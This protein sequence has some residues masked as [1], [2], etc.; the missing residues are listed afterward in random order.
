V[1]DIDLDFKTV[2]KDGTEVTNRQLMQNGYAPRYLD[3]SGKVKPYQL[4][5]IGQRKDA[6]LAVLKEAQHQGQK[7]VLDIP[8]KASEI[9]RNEFKLVKEAFWRS[10]VEGM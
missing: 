6:T 5:H 2:L 9:N 8:G 10:F 4:H 1:Q 3:A 7:S